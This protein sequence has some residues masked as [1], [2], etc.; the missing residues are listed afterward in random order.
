[1]RSCS[2]LAALAIGLSSVVAI[3]AQS[4]AQQ[5]DR[6]EIK[7]FEPWNP[8]GLSIGIAVVQKF[9]GKCFATSA[10][11][12]SR[13]DAWRCSAGNLIQDPCYMQLMGDQKQLACAQDPWSANINLLTLDA[14]L[15]TDSRKDM[16]RDD[17]IPWALE[18]ADGSHCT[19]MTGGTFAVAG[20]RANYGCVGG[21]TLF[22]DIDKGS[23]VWRIF[24][25]TDKSIALTQS[26]I[27]VAWY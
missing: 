20:M 9:S 8:N 12:A 3:H 17:S 2:Y 19:L 16:K 13:P 7:L 1:M 6:T 11:S 18:L 21:R 25:M 10:A 15:P 23:P 4:Q 27:T 22:G 24:S 5:S 26:A 14:P